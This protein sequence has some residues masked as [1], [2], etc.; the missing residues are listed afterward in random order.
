DRAGP[1]Q[2]LVRQRA[3]AVVDV[4]DDREVADAGGFGHGSGGWL[5]GSPFRRGPS[6]SPVRSGSGDLRPAGVSRSEDHATTGASASL[7]P[8]RAAAEGAAG[9]RKFYQRGGRMNR[10]AR[11]GVRREGV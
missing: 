4:G 3:L 1:E 11:R 10:A 2:E 9:L 6:A 5:A 7:A 8:A